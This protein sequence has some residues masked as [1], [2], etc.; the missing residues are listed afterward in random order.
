MAQAACDKQRRS[1]TL[2]LR[3]L[4]LSRFPALS[5]LPGQRQAQEARCAA[6]G[7][8]FMFNPISASNPKRS[9]GRLRES[10]TTEPPQPEKGACASRALLVYVQTT[11]ARIGNFHCATPFHGAALDAS[12]KR[13]S[14][15]R[16]LR[17]FR[18]LLFVVLPSVPAILVSGLYSARVTRPCR[19]RGCTKRYAFS[20]PLSGRRRRAVALAS[21]RR[22][23][24]TCR[25]PAYSFHE[26]GLER[27]R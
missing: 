8:W 10:C 17:N 15:T 27:G 7:N 18:R 11:A 4:P 6:E 1:D 13:K 26:D 22:S 21:V 16:A 24:C 5:K 25:F 23:N 12:K 9:P 2:P 19:P 3:I 20:G 14:P